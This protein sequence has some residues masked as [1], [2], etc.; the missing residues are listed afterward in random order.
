MPFRMGAVSAVM[1]VSGGLAWAAR[2]L[3]NKCRI[4][5]LSCFALLLALHANHQR[6]LRIIHRVYLSQSASM[7]QLMLTVA[8]NQRVGLSGLHTCPTP[9][10]L[11]RLMRTNLPLVCCT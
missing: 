2:S 6:I 4:V 11:F 7:E 5:R 3:S 8:L 9:M 10:L 1:I